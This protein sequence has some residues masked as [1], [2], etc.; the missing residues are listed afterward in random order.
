MSTPEQIQAPPPRTRRSSKRLLVELF[1]VT[2]GVLIAL[3]IQ[4]LVDWNHFRLLVRDAHQTITREITNNRGELEGFIKAREGRNAQLRNALQFANDMLT[5]KAGNAQSVS[6][7][8]SF[9][10]LASSAWKTAAQTG[11]L[12]HMDYDD[13]QRYSHLYALQELLENQ[14]RRTLEHVTA[15]ISLVGIAGN[16]RD[17]PLDD[18]RMFRVRLLDLIGQM[19]VT[20]QLAEQLLER[21]TQTLAQ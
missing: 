11:A 18:L 1:I 13:V 10:D 14:Q 17:V 7:G 5:K 9:P 8:V 19:L 21:Y 20:D 2:A 3:L 16:P 6:I 12:A 15:A 4:S